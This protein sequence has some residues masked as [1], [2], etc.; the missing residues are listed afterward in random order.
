MTPRIHSNTVVIATKENVSCDLGEEAAILGM[1][2]SVYY[3][4]NP[5]GACIWRLL[6]QP[7]TVREI[8]D[9]IVNEYDVTEDRAESDLLQLLEQM[10]KEGLVELK[11]SF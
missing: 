6:Q 11:P 9:A 3:G 2:N 8:C 7:R 5:V 10:A 4:L 1:K